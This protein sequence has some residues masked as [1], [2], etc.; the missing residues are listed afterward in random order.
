MADTSPAK[1]M[2]GRLYRPDRRAASDSKVI[3]GGARKPTNIS[4]W[5]PDFESEPINAC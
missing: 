5:D 1:A 3:H 4:P 2:N